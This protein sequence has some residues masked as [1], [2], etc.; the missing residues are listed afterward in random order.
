[1][2][3]FRCDDDFIPYGALQ[4]VAVY[5][6]NLQ[7]L[8]FVQIYLENIFHTVHLSNYCLSEV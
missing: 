3:R 1:M 4:K 5:E 2:S 8:S 6:R 7:D